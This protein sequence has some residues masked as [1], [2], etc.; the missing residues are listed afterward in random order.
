MRLNPDGTYKPWSKPVDRVDKAAY[1]H[2]LAYAQHEDTANRNAADR[3][4]IAEMNNIN[5]PSVREH[6]ERAIVKP[7]LSTKAHFGLW[8]PNKNLKNIMKK[9]SKAVEGAEMDRRYAVVRER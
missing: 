8:V 1:H 2:D 4:M 3:E 5:N 7:I 9:V 6:I